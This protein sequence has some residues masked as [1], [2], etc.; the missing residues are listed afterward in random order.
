M[1]ARRLTQ[2]WDLGEIP[3]QIGPRERPSN[4]PFPDRLPFALGVDELGVLVQMP[5]T[6]VSRQL[7][8]VYRQGCQIGTPMDDQGLGKSYGEDFYEFLRA[9]LPERPAAGLEVLEIGCGSGYLLKKLEQLGARV[10]GIEPD[11]RCAELCAREG[12]RVIADEFD[13]DRFERPFDVILHYAVLEHIADAA[14]FLRD[15]VA[16]LSPGGVLIFSVPDETPNIARGDLYML[17]HQHWNYFSRGSLRALA[18]AVGARIMAFQAARVGE[19]VYA[20]W[21]RAEG[22]PA[23]EAAITPELSG[24]APETYRERALANLD[25]LSTYIEGARRRGESLGIYCPSRAL[26]YLALLD[27]RGLSLRFFDDDPRVAGRYYPPFAIPVEDR[28]A[29]RARPADQILILSRSFGPRIAE[30]LGAAAEL[31]STRVVQVADLF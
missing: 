18:S 12:I 31:R 23:D 5:N 14:S 17:Y 28:A 20:A 4:D 25:T 7:T 13:R 26:T 9:H 19:P 3:F 8:E 22:A 21:T 15:Q 29:L 2:L 24:P 11:R 1:N 27:L 10:T 16:L 30:S 6:E